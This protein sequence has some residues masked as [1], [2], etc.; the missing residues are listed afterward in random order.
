ML[1]IKLYIGAHKTA[2]THLQRLLDINR[3]HLLAN[4]IH[5]SIPSDLRPEWMPLFIKTIN[6]K[7]KILTEKLYTMS[8]NHGTWIFSEEN[9]SGTPYDLTIKSSIYP[10]LKERLEHFQNLFKDAEIEV[11]F[12][13]RSYETYYRSAYLEVIR[14]RGY[15]PFNDFYDTKRFNLNRWES[16][17]DAITKVIAPN[18]V[19]LWCYE[20]IQ[21]L[22][23]II[24][25]NLTKLEN[26]KTLTD[27]YNTKITRPSISLKTLR[28]LK[29]LDKIITRKES[30]ILIKHLNR[31]YPASKLNGRVLPF[32]TSDSNNFRDLY[33]DSIQAILHQNPKINF[34]SAEKYKG[35]YPR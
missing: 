22:T 24:L 12:S 3:D 8:P 19:T 29:I 34:L 20:D 5:L 21:P 30:I 13:I 9:F 4:D 2:T 32:N 35:V 7:D 15:L 6:S 17:I 14:N 31:K 1:K 27:S 11:F 28:I 23:P 10:N 33:R 25:H 18:K 26:I 16:V